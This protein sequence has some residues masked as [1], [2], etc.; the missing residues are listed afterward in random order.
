MSRRATTTSLRRRSHATEHF[1]R[2]RVRGSV[3]NLLLVLGDQLS[4]RAAPLRSLDAARDAVLLLEVAGESRHVPSHKQRTTLF[5]AAMRHFALD[6][7]K[8]GLRVHYVAL[9]DPSNTHSLD[10]E[11]RRAVDELRP[12][13]MHVVHPGEWRI[14]LMLER[15]RRDLPIPTA[16]HDDDHFLLPPA[17]F[18]AWAA[19]RRQLVLEHFYRMMR[20]RCGIL[21]REDGEPEGG[22]WNYDADNR[23]PYRNGPTPSP[24]VRFEPDAVTREVIH[25]VCERL[26]E[27]P[28][29]LDHFS[30][31]V[32]RRD[33]LRALRD[34]VT[35]RL[36]N[37]G[38][39][40]DAMVAGQPF[41]FHSVLSPALNLKLLDPRE[42]I[43]AALAAWRNGRAPLQSVEGFVRQVLGWREFIRG[44]YWHAG[45]EYAGMNGLQQHGRLPEFYWT[46]DTDAR[47][48]KLCLEQVLQHGYGHHIQR[49]MV[50]GNFALIAGVHPRQISNWYLGMYVDAVDWVTLPN[51][52]GM[53]M[54]ADGGLV[55]TKPYAAG[56]RYIDKMSDY[57][58][59]CSYDPTQRTGPR[60]CPFTTLYWDFLARNQRRLARNPRMSVVLQSL[61]RMPA[62]EIDAIRAAAR[63]TRERMGVGPSDGGS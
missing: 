14:M 8:R 13:T 51:T 21:L 57:C 19:G 23:R 52:L 26:P 29:R 44:I 7:V 45:P 37:F 3:R 24:P 36:P 12:Q 17:E 31:P 25:L 27:L 33:A 38:P 60:A 54:H 46:G 2:L 20:R 41:L 11:L 61:R 30:W 18:A 22:R 34:F 32:A 47:C 42:V 16:V 53:V 63:T 40:Q 50:T 58:R 49:L 9:D 28:G 56:G 62:A 6:L 4:A 43:D 59:G 10:T 55:G 15:W 35:H 1:P 5:L 48:L 39:Y